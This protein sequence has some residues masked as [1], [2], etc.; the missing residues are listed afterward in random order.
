MTR[1]PRL[2]LHCVICKEW[3]QA[4]PHCAHGLEDG[5]NPGALYFAPS[6]TLTLEIGTRAAACLTQ[7]NLVGHAGRTFYVEQLGRRAA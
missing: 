3:G 6:R 4:E 7:E 5:V 2:S 1:N